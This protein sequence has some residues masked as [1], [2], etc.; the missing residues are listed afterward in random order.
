MEWCECCA[1]AACHAARSAG[2]GEAAGSVR[3]HGAVI[4]V[5]QRSRRRCVSGCTSGHEPHPLVRTT[6]PLASTGV[7]ARGDRSG[8]QP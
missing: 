4:S 8:D 6:A 2:H 7:A 5:L 3:C 1:V